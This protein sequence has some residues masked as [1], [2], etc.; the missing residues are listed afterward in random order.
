MH[1][2]KIQITECILSFEVWI[3]MLHNGCRI[4]EI[5]VSKLFKCSSSHSWTHSAVCMMGKIANSVFVPVEPKLF[6]TH[7][8]IMYKRPKG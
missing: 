1:Y 5:V 7:A 3:E 2:S 6:L 8:R 4:L